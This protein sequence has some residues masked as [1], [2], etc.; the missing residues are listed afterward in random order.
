[1]LITCIMNSI[2]HC[3]HKQTIFHCIVIVFGYEIDVFQIHISQ[4]PTKTMVYNIYG[5]YTDDIALRT[6]VRVICH[7]CRSVKSKPGLLHHHV[8]GKTNSHMICI[9]ISL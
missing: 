1:M 2:R 5:V 6:Y 8:G 3:L 9:L 7:Q 4:Q